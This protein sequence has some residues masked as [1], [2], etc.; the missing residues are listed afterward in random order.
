MA[1]PVPTKM[2][3]KLSPDTAKLFVPYLPLSCPLYSCRT[4]LQRKLP[5]VTISF[6]NIR[7]HLLTTLFQYIDEWV[8][9]HKS[10]KCVIKV[11]L[12]I[13]SLLQLS[14]LRILFVNK[15]WQTT[16]PLLVIWCV[17]VPH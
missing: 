5:E 16:L 6:G 8:I 4:Y 1:L 7:L 2:F 13:F 12:V 14:N 11:L 10:M 17:C 15:M 3:L 9:V